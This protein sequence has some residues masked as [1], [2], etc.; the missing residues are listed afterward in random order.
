MREHESEVDPLEELARHRNRI[1]FELAYASEAE[2][3]SQ[4]YLV[5]EEEMNA[6]TRRID[7]LRRQRQ[8]RAG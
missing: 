5:K 7:Q 1:A 8:E 3:V 6:C 4:R 2:R